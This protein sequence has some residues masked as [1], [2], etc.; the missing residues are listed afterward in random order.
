[1]V[2]VLDMKRGGPVMGFISPDSAA[3]AK[4]AVQRKGY[5]A[6]TELAKTFAW[7]RPNDMIWNNF[8]NNY[9]LGN[10]PPAL[11]LLFWNLD[12]M[13]MPAALHRDM[14]D[15]GVTNSLARP[16]GLTMLGTPLDL[17]KV[18]CDAYV[19]GGETDHLT[20]WQSCY[21][22]TQLFGGKT[23]FALSTS[24]HIAAVIHPPGNPKSTYRIGDESKADPEDWLETAE[25]H[26]GTWWADWAPW[27]QE[28]SGD[29]KP[30]PEKLGNSSHEP[31]EPAPGTYV[32]TRSKG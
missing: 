14:L 13:N 6:G 20:P 25:L 9:F 11:D 17:G 31:M 30:A 21:R 19:A 27:L 1:M 2:T 32:F 26:P 29:L 12:S 18:T 23:R 28:R 10:K 24:G 5:L 3:A 22:T 15:I 8:V 4:A 16:G 7:L